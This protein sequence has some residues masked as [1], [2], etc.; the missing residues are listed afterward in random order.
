[1]S[2]RRRSLAL[3][4][5]VAALTV[6]G[7]AAA[8]DVAARLVASG[9]SR[10][11]YATHAPGDE[12]RLFIIEKRGRIRILNLDTESLNSDYFLDIDSI[13]TG[14]T[15]T[16]SE[17][18]LLGLAFHPDYQNNG[19]F[20]VYYTATAGSGDSYIRRYSRG[21]DADHASTSGAVPMAR[22]CTLSSASMPPAS[23][24]SSRP[25]ETCSSTACTSARRRSATRGFVAGAASSS[26]AGASAP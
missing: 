14:G 18:G 12:S 6:S 23:S 4:A 25:P 3:A 5:S 1:M 16:S 19:Y 9:L 24:T 15:T 13:V 20:Y 8:Q 7:I 17:Q 2:I 11:I 10:P 26:S 22:Y 21:A